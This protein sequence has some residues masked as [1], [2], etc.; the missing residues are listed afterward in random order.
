LFVLEPLFLY[1]WFHRQA[2]ANNEKAFYYLQVMHT[3]L[4]SIILAAVFAGVAGV[5][6]LFY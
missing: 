6:A 1:K 4:L 3:V 2:E 5:H